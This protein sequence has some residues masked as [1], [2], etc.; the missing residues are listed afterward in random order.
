M[1]ESQ[2]RLSMGVDEGDRQVRAL[3]VRVVTQAWQRDR[4]DAQPGKLLVGIHRVVLAAGQGH[5]GPGSCQQLRHVGC[6][7]GERARI[8]GQPPLPVLL[9]Q[10]GLHR[11]VVGGQQADQTRDAQVAR[12][13]LLA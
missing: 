3:D 7:D 5:R 2:A 6:P 8:H 13:R 10:A 4:G 11:R 12:G 1:G 9:T